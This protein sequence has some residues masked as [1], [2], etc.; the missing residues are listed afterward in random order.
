VASLKAKAIHQN[1]IGLLI[2]ALLLLLVSTPC[3]FSTL[4]SNTEGGNRSPGPLRQREAYEKF[5]RGERLTDLEVEDLA[6]R[7][8]YVSSQE[9]NEGARTVMMC[10]LV[11]FLPGVGILVYLLKTRDQALKGI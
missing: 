5:K 4:F 6:N 8:V 9:K 10:S 3:L 2:A 11:F 7:E 1:R